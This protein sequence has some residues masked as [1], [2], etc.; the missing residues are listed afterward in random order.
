MKLAGKN[1]L[2]L[3][4][5]KHEKEKREKDK[6]CKEEK[7]IGISKAKKKN[8]YEYRKH[9]VNSFTLYFHSLIFFSRK[10]IA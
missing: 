10:I 1:L 7:E 8:K 4:R 2:G 9:R 3:L 5:K 6:F